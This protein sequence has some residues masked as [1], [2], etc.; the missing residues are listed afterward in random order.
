M[1]AASAGRGVP[2]SRRAI[3]ASSSLA[4]ASAAPGR[5]RHAVS[6]QPHANVAAA[7]RSYAGRPHEAISLIASAGASR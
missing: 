5:R 4:D 6:R 2:T 3:A 1:V 7:L